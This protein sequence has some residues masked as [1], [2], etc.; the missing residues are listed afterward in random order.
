MID[1]DLIARF[2]DPPREYGPTP[3]WWWSGGKV[4]REGIRWQLQRFTEGRI[5]N[6]VLMNLAPKGPTY[7]AAPDD[8]VWFSEEWWELF[9][10][11][12]EVA[13]EL[14]IKLW[15]YD[16]IGFSGANIQGQITARHPEAAGRAI[17]S[18]EASVGEG[19]ELPLLPREHLVGVYGERLGEK[20]W[21]TLDWAD[22]R[23][24]AA[25]GTSVRIVT[26]EEKAFDYLDVD[27][28][29]LL[30]DWVHGEFVRRVGDHVGTTIVGSFQDEL[31]AMPTWSAGFCEAFELSLI[32][33]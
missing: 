20:G 30:I 8:P 28:V 17:R 33:I 23:V 10:Y 7:G 5:D 32:H 18:R 26:W 21:R 27:A 13:R 25:P 1:A 6:L 4:T 14:G 31:P 24:D 15:F 9:A 11:T 3:L 29:A 16:Q 19:C 2:D 22:G 12:C